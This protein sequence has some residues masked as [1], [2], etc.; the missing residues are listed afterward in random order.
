MKRIMFLLAF[1][2]M[3]VFTACSDDDKEEKNA[4]NGSKWIWENGIYGLVNGGTWYQTI[5]FTSNNTYTHYYKSK[6][7]IIQDKTEGSKYEYNHPNVVLYRKDGDIWNTF[8]LKNEH[9]MYPKTNENAVF[10]KQ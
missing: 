1:L 3:F 2:P 6:D 10:E 9:Q 8:I 7:G 5:E 4:L